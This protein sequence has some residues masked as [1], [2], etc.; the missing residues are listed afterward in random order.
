MHAT[1]KTVKVAK[2]CEKLL[3]YHEI[4]LLRFFCLVF[5]LFCFVFEIVLE[6]RKKCLTDQSRFSQ[7]KAKF[8]VKKRKNELEKNPE[9]ENVSG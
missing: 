1:K 4:Y 9:N 2:S 8:G 6:K 7:L 5:V 3:I